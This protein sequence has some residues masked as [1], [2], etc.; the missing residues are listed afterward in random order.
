MGIN[1]KCPEC[2]SSHVQQ[3]SSESDQHVLYLILFG[4]PYFVWLI[5][6]WGIGFCVLLCWDS[7]MA[8]VH[9]MRGKSHVWQSKKCFFNRRRIYFCH[10]CGHNFR[11]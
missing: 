7:W 11:I 8:I 10:D 2:G 9:M 1:F 6:R 5:I 4:L 3:F